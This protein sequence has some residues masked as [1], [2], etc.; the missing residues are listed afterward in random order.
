MLLTSP[1]QWGIQ[2]TAKALI[3]L[4]VKPVTH[5]RRQVPAQCSGG[6]VH[7]FALQPSPFELPQP[8]LRSLP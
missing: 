4:S 7:V 8:M 2:G 1:G 6:T 3:H 5:V